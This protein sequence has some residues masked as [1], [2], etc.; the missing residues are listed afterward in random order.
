MEKVSTKSMTDESWHDSSLCDR[1]QT[2]QCLKKE[3]QEDS[4]WE[5]RYKQITSCEKWL[6]EVN[7]GA[8]LRIYNNKNRKEFI[9]EKRALQKK[10]HYQDDERVVF[11]WY[12]G[13]VVPRLLPSSR[14]AIQ[15]I[16]V[17]LK[18]G[19]QT[20]K[21]LMIWKEQKPQYVW[22]WKITNEPQA[23]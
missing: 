15:V 20:W 11:C 3:N 14:L 17:T 8:T 7:L 5:G 6:H 19:Q 9:T 16:W 13:G 1:T 23:S 2:Q 12:P 21:I 22:L 4:D 10:L 18:I